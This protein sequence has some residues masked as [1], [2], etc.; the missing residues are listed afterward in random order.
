MENFNGLW[1]FRIT[2]NNKN[3]CD[4]KICVICKNIL[5]KFYKVGIYT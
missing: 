4:E 1:F 3:I 2:F 5:V